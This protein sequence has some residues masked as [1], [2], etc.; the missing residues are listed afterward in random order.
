MKDISY[1]FHNIYFIYILIYMKDIS[2][3][4]GNSL[5]IVLLPK[6]L[7]LSEANTSQ[8]HHQPSV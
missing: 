8:G 4:Y 3:I 6:L 1:I 5:S 2:Y 7:S